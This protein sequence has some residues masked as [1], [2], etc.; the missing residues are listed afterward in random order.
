MTSRPVGQEGHCFLVISNIHDD[1][2]I[3]YA[4]IHTITGNGCF[5][6]QKG[7]M[8]KVRAYILI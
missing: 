4:F 6:L 8:T 7:L 3:Y 2:L 5:Q 1:L